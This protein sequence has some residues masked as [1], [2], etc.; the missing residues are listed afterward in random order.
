MDSLRWNEFGERPIDE[1]SRFLCLTLVDLEQ[2]D[3][4]APSTTSSA[5][6]RSLSLSCLPDLVL[7]H[8]ADHVMTG[9]RVRG[10]GRA[11]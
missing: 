1:V 2:A 8:R 7:R 9:L 3:V 11:G 10:C 4:G 6:A 5:R